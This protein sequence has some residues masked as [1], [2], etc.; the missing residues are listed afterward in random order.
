MFWNR[1][2]VVAVF[3][4]A[5]A[6]SLTA[7]VPAVA[8]LKRPA[9]PGEPAAA[10]ARI[11]AAQRILNQLPIRFEVNEGQVDPRVKYYARGPEQ[12]L[13]LTPAGA[14]LSLPSGTLSMRLASSNPRP[15]IEGLDLL[16]SWSSYLIGNRPERW[17]P[18][19]RHYRRVRYRGV[20]PGI[21]LIYYGKGRQLEHDFVVAPGADPSGIRMRFEGAGRISLGAD[22]SLTLD[23]GGSEVRFSRPVA[24]QVSGG[25]SS[26]EREP[27]A[28]AYVRLGEREVGFTVGAY[29]PRRP[30]V[31]DPVLSYSTY[32]GG[33]Y[34]DEAT[35]VT[36]D[37]QG[38][39][40]VTG[41]TETQDFP[42]LG[43]GLQGT[44]GGARNVFLTKLNPFA[45]TGIS[46]VYS[47]FLGGL[48]DEEPSAIAVDAAGNVYLTGTTKSRDFP[49]TDS[50]FRTESGSTDQNAFAMKINVD[51]P[52]TAPILYATYLGGAKAELAYG[53]TVDA[54][55]RIYVTG[56]TESEDFPL[57]G[58]P[59]QPS[60]RG[61]WDAFLSIVDPS[62]SGADSLPYSTY[63]GGNSTDVGISVVLGEG[64]EV[65]FS[66]YTM[67]TDFPV[68]GPAYQ[69]Q[70]RGLGDVFLTRLDL[71]K[72]GLA[73][74]TYST[75]LGGSD[76]EMPYGLVRDLSGK[77]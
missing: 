44:G 10:R 46:L 1:L 14:V 42:T 21:D 68:T 29:D 65:Y 55:G 74:L 77:F 36:V 48:G 18:H 63:F 34:Y 20:Y 33:S 5:T 2:R 43:R 62:K 9:A 30:L 40:W 22:G 38:Y 37:S 6:V 71:S 60:G 69:G 13:Y 26:P 64:Q 70:Q 58:D 50:G 75:Y 57:T 28:S 59:V 54:A 4:L 8:A 66:G 25:N 61:G 45:T 24:Y 16:P 52:D 39:I 56:V 35:A 32:L 73:A 23:V 51:V 15:A 67:S 12:I 11:E 49:V 76:F 17:Q 7:T 72:S 53:A 19:V 47:G 3:L 27:V 41:N 31:I